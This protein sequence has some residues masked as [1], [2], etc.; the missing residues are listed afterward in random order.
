MKRQSTLLNFFNARETE[1]KVR[2]VNS[3]NDENET[4]TTCSNNARECDSEETQEHQ[5]STV[6]S[7]NIV[8]AYPAIWSAEQWENFST[9]NPWLV[10]AKLM[11]L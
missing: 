2:K 6:N 9:K 7:E 5:I 1:S 8:V 3:E 4:L 11:Y 10:A